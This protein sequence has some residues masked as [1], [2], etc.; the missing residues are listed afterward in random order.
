[1]KCKLYKGPLHNKTMEISDYM[2]N[3]GRVNLTVKDPK[4]KAQRFTSTSGNS[5]M[6]T[7]IYDGYRVVEYEVKIMSCI[8]AGRQYYGPPMHPDGSLI[9]K[10]MEGKK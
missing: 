2:L 3:M 9:L 5:T 8:I 1:M 4:S 6:T 7:Q 10:Y